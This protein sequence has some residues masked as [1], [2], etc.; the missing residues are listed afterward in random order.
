[1]LKHIIIPLDGSSLA[2]DA[3]EQ[4]LNIVEP[5]GKITLVSAI[6]A[7]EVPIYGYYPPVTMTDY[8]DAKNSLLPYARHYLQGIADR[9]NEHGFTVKIEAH[10]GDPAQII[11]DI[12]EKCQADA[13]VMSTHGRSGLSRWLFGSV[14]NKVL[15]AKLC[16]VYVIPSKET[17]KAS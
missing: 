11:T 9:L 2:E 5:K 14:T 13:I 10:I 7:P 16:P 15:S 17:R 6:E 12:A 1:M 3:V 4:A 8:E